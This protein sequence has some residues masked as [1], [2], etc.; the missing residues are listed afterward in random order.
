VFDT[1]ILEKVVGEVLIRVVLL[2]EG[3]LRACA[4]GCSPTSGEHMS[5]RTSP[6]VNNS[7]FISLLPSHLEEKKYFHRNMGTYKIREAPSSVMA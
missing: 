7:L 2:R 6:Y 5:M 4:Q 1:N 3:H